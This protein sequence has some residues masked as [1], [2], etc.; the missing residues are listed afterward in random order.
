MENEDLMDPAA[1]AASSSA[2]D[3]DVAQGGASFKLLGKQDCF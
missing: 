1:A 2:N 3:A